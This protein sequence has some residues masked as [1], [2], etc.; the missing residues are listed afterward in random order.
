MHYN[1]I[2]IDWQKI[3]FQRLFPVLT[4]SGYWAQPQIHLCQTWFIFHFR[5]FPRRWELHKGYIPVSSFKQFLESLAGSF[6]CVEGLVKIQ[7]GLLISKGSAY[8]SNSMSNVPEPGQYP[9][10]GNCQHDPWHQ[11]L[12]YRPGLVF[13]WH[14]ILFLDS[15]FRSSP[16]HHDHWP[17]PNRWN[18]WEKTFWVNNNPTQL[19]HC[20]NRPNMKGFLALQYF[21]L[22]D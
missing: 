20:C 10:K 2:Y 8:N 15:T 17:Q 22:Y 3:F 7:F 14:F 5:Y 9:L 19:G 16:I 13:I 12:K 4:C 21:I 1:I 11:R 18:I 6:T